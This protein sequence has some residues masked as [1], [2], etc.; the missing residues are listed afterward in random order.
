MSKQQ[1]PHAG[2]FSRFLDLISGRL[3]NRVILLTQIVE[4]LI[5]NQRDLEKKL[6]EMGQQMTSDIEAIRAGI[7]DLRTKAEEEDVDFSDEFA[8]ID[9]AVAGLHRVAESFKS[10]TATVSEGGTSS[11]AAPTGQTGATEGTSGGA[12][13]PSDVS[14]IP[15]TDTGQGTAAQ[16]PG[17]ASGAGAAGGAIDADVAIPASGPQEPPAASGEV[18][19]G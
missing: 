9:S 8:T 10:T 5:M 3:H 6:G 11:T 4:E 16:S 1:T 7:N 2:P 17:A 19:E 14:G 13:V 15:P 18:D 12:S